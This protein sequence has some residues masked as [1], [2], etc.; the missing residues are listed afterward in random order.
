MFLFPVVFGRFHRVFQCYLELLRFCLK[1]VWLI[2]EWLQMK[3]K[4]FVIETESGNL[5]HLRL[6]AFWDVFVRFI[7]VRIRRLIGCVCFPFVIFNV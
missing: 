2:L 1:V 5:E 4:S 3:G 7:C 6:T